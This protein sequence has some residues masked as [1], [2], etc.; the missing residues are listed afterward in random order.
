M[1]RFVYLYFG[2]LLEKEN[3]MTDKVCML[4]KRNEDEIPIIPVHY[5]R[6]EYWICT[7]HLPVLIHE[8][9]KLEGK[10]PDVGSI[11]AG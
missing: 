6:N 1:I 4:C 5:K 2:H 3:I 11:A 9:S 7:Q 10:L 8:P